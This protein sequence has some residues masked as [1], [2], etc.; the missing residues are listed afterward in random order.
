MTALL[1]RILAAQS[2]DG[3]L[4]GRPIAEVRLR[5][6]PTVYLG[7]RSGAVD[8]S[9]LRSRRARV[10]RPAPGSIHLVIGPAA[11]AWFAQ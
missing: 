4:G 8:A 6:Q 1:A 11:G 9:T 7:A 5:C 3:A 2:A 10:A